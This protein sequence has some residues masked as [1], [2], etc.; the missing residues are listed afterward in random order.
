MKAGCTN[1][2]RQIGKQYLTMPERSLRVNVSCSASHTNKGTIAK[3]V[4]RT[5][6]LTKAS[7]VPIVLKCC[8]CLV[9][10]M[11]INVN[12]RMSDVWLILRVDICQNDTV[13]PSH[14]KINHLPVQNLWFCL[15]HVLLAM[16]IM[17]IYCTSHT[18]WR[19]QVDKGFCR[20]FVNGHIQL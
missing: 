11:I 18:R 7:I 6:H 8:V 19:T 20:T 10:L 17:R 3:L 4:L 13:D 14:Q 2:A 1:R 12:A 15:I 9:T 16:M 5:S